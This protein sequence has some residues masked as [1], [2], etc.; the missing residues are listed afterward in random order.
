MKIAAK[1]FLLMFVKHVA[2]LR[3]TCEFRLNSEECKV[4]NLKVLEGDIEITSV[5]GQH[6]IRKTNTDVKEIWVKEI[7]RF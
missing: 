5:T 1:L 7:L 4:I 2:G 6:A 3:L